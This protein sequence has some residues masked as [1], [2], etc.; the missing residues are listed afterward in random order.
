MSGF[1]VNGQDLQSYAYLLGAAGG[2]PGNQ[3]ETVDEASRYLAKY[4]T[5]PE[6]TSNSLFGR[7]GVHHAEIYG[8]VSRGLKNTDHALGGSAQALLTL[9]QNH[10]GAQGAIQA[11]IGAT[12][13][14]VSRPPPPFG[15]QS[16][17]TVVT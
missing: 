17:F 6:G 15:Y 2:K 1:S 5:L 11:Q 4:A 9:K 12:L 3:Q 13:P 7:V 16:N 8:A 14:P 10:A